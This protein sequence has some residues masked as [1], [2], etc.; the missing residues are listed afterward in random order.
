MSSS[1]HRHRM[2]IEKEA[3]LNELELRRHTLAR[4]LYASATS[5]SPVVSAGQA[6]AAPRAAERAKYGLL[7][8]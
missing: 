1:C 5:C 2:L 3:R 6:K 4:P 8:I 7:S